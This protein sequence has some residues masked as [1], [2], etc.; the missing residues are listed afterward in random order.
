L[1]SMGRIDAS[2]MPPPQAL[3]FRSKVLTRCGSGRP[4]GSV[5]RPAAMGD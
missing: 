1:K 3:Y 2:G 5:P 4:I